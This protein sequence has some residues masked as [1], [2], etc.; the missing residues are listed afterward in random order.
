MDGPFP[1]LKVPTLFGKR[2]IRISERMAKF[3]IAIAKIPSKS[4]R[5][6][7]LQTPLRSLNR[8]LDRALEKVKTDGNVTFVTFL[9]HPHHFGNYRYNKLIMS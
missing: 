7:I 3:L 2:T 8:A 4:P 6:T 5:K 9:S 1:L